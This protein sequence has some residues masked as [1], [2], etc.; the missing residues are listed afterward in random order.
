MVIVNIN[1]VLNLILWYNLLNTKPRRRLT[2]AYKCSNRM[3]STFLPPVIDDYVTSQDPVR[4]YDAFVDALDFRSLGISLEPKAGAD[5][6]YPKEMLKLII[7]GYSYG[8]RSSRKLERACH[9]NL[10]FQWLMGGEK[11]DYRTI[12]RFRSKHKEAIR[13]LLKQC[14]RMCMR[15]ELIEGN[16]LFVDGSKFRANASINNTWTKKK[17]ERYLEKIDKH[18]DQLLKECEQVDSEED[19]EESMAQLKKQIK[20]KEQLVNKIKGVLNNLDEAQ[21]TSINS[22]DSDCVKTTGRQGKHASYNVQSTTDKKHGLIVHAEA[23]CQSSDLNQLASQVEK[24]TETL[25]RKPEIVA[26][27]AGYASTHDIKKISKDVMVVVPSQ[28]QSQ[29]EKNIHPIK[30]FAK[31]EFKYDKD[32]DEYICPENKR[33]KY[34]GITCKEPLKKGYRARREDCYQCPQFGVC[35]K[36]KSGRKI[37]RLADE[38]FKEQIEAIYA[39]PEGQDVYKYRKEKVELPFGHMKRNLGAGQFMLR[40]KSKVNAEVSI[41]STCFNIARMITIL[42]IPELIL[43]LNSN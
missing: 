3:Q 43:K 11:P 7:Y 26:S 1:I 8:I 41:L 19:K 25:Q 4:I 36:S 13:K 27:D 5:E 14:V 32:K 40:G 38:A 31:E 29:K 33:L 42:G 34:K 28:K 10:S 12:A 39:S 17:C 23:V 37:I 30:P 35:T 20:D 18:I 21:K 15:L 24:S 16:T 6:Y 22:T 2:M 9:H